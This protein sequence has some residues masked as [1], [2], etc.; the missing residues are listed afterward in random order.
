MSKLGL[1][2]HLTLMEQMLSLNY[3][4]DLQQVGINPKLPTLFKKATL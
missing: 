4:K 1:A 2:H 3:Q